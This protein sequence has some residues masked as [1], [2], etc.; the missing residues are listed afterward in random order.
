MEGDGIVGLRKSDYLFLII[1][2]NPFPNLISALTRVKVDGKICCL[3]TKESCNS[4][5][6]EKIYNNLNNIIK[7]KYEDKIE[8]EPM[9]IDK[10]NEKETKKKMDD[11]LRDILLSLPKNSRIELNFTGGTKVMASSAYYSFKQKAMECSGD[12]TYLLSYIDSEKERIFY[13]IIENKVVKNCEENLNK[14]ECYTNLGVSDIISSHGFFIGNNYNIEP[15]DAELGERIFNTFVDV[16]KERYLKNIK[17]LEYC[18]VNLGKIKDKVKSKPENK[19]DELIKPRVEKLGNEIFEGEF[20]PFHNVNCFKDL[21]VRD[22][23]VTYN[24]INSLCGN[25]FEDYIFNIILNLK[26]EGLIIDAL[27]SVKKDE[28]GEFEVDIVALKKYKIFSISITSQENED[29]AILKLF[30]VKERAKQLG[31]DE[32]GICFISLC[33]NS[34]SIERKFMNIWDK[35][36]PKNTLIIGV[37]RFK[38]IKERLRTWITG[39]ETANY[40]K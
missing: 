30:E 5:N 40:D 29:E 6:T 14:M 37:D 3:Y 2:T 32:S 21:A 28:K 17:F 4:S 39:G 9:K 23:D 26:E 1:G 34:K 13:E 16:D 35:E 8:I 20:N 19:R 31:G 7:A 33:E 24:L 12:F 18:F 10:N 11:K 36:S 25:W 27:N 22:D 38:D 15:Y